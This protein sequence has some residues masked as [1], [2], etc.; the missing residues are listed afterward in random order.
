[1]IDPIVSEVRKY[2]ME[3]TQR[4]SGK[5]SEICKDLRKF[6]KICGHRVVRLPT[7]RIQPA[8]KSTFPC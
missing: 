4:F 8:E 5:L 7:R 2:R 6:Q 3:H 1:M